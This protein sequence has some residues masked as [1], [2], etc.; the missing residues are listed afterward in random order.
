MTLYFLDNVFLLNLALE[1]AKGIFQRLA[2]LNSHFGQTVTPPDR[3]RL[4]FSSYPNLR[5]LSQAGFH[6]SCDSSFP[7]SGDESP[8]NLL[9]RS[10]LTQNRKRTEYCT[11]RAA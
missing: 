10:C 6:D 9:M 11:W 7:C 8:A 5:L 4:D 3:S 1:A 2:L